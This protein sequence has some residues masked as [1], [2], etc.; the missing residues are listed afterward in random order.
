M[1]PILLV[2]AYGTDPVR[3]KNDMEIQWV[4]KR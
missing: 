3:K 4:N 2:G 1:R